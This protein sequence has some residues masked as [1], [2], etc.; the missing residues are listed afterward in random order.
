MKSTRTV[1]ALLVGATLIAAAI[2]PVMGVTPAASAGVVD[3]TCDITATLNFSPPLTLSEQQN[4]GM[5]LTD[6]SASDCM[7]IEYGGSQYTGGTFTLFS[8]T[9][10]SLCL[11]LDIVGTG[12]LAWNNSR[13]ISYFDYT[14]STNPVSGT[15]GLEATITNG[16]FQGDV[17]QDVPDSVSV[18]G[19]CAGSGITSITL[20]SG[21]LIFTSA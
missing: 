19:S 11:V 2:V 9:G 4:Q 18:N 10:T 20:N 5:S 12:Q 14:V 21:L 6:A 16:P 13:Q 1:R 7:D 17:I 8:G 15:V 3:N